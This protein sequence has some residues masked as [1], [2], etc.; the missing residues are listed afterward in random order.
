[1]NE[2]DHGGVLYCQGTA[3]PTAGVGIQDFHKGYYRE[4]GSGGSTC[5]T[6]MACISHKNVQR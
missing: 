2:W 3:E 1:M 4:I 5:N 6:Q